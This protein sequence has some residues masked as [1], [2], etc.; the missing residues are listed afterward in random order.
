M[1]NAA[2]APEPSLILPS[3]S[4]TRRLLASRRS[5][6]T[7]AA[8]LIAAFALYW[9][10][11][12]S[13]EQR[14]ATAFFGADTGQY[15]QLA[16]GEFN[17]RLLRLHPV[18]VA[19]ALVWMKLFSPL[20]AW[21]GPLA[22]LK[23][24][25]A[26]I[27]AIG[28]AAAF[29]A[30]SVFTPRREA[31]LWGVIYASS[32]AV[33][34]FSSIEESKIVSTTLA[35]IY[36]AIYLHLRSNWSRSRAAAL[37]VVFFAACLNEITAAFLA[38]I[39]ALD[40]ILKHRLQLRA[41]TWLALH[42]LVAPAALLV[43]EFG[44]R[45]SLA[46]IAAI[47]EGNT[48]VEIFFYYFSRNVYDLKTLSDFLHRW[49]LFNIA[50]PEPA[51]RH[52]NMNIGYGGDFDATL[53][54]YFSSP[55]SAATLLSLAAVFV[56]ALCCRSRASG[57]PQAKGIMPGLAAYAAVRMIFFFLFLPGECLLYSPSV[58]LAHL[59]FLAI[60]FAASQFRYKTFALAACALLLFANNAVFI[61]AAQIVPLAAQ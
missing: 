10:S 36:V 29:S 8:I 50:A 27:G 37:T 3:D 12:F 11:S 57:A 59:L 33:W 17:D 32:T 49:F 58:T 4:G 48:F 46:A 22:V 1:S 42:A 5:G 15:T 47:P 56:A 28:A 20:T 18:T 6:L 60:P 44:I 61:F 19:L 30:F 13:L 24:M 51:I 26:L 41:Y 54:G 55:L 38:A 52:A 40:L 39:P 14:H 23:A 9:T 45:R 31:L 16:A 43:L 34:Y 25:F 21:L 2:G 35:A 53:L 7:T